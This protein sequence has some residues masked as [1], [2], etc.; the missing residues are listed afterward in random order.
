MGDYVLTSVNR[1]ITLFSHVTPCSFT[2]NRSFFVFVCF[3]CNSPQWARASSFTRVLDHT[4]RHTTVG[5]TPL[6]ESSARRRDL[7]LTTLTADKYPYPCGIRTH[8]LSRRVAA[9]R[10]LRP[11]VQITELPKKND[12]LIIKGK[13]T[14]RRLM[15]YI[16]GAPILDVS[17]SHTTTQHSR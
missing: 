17:R 16:Y 13:L 4:Q 9:N 2:D 11:R 15:S 6:D 5:R 12:D 1:K 8:N 7:Y 3:W 14:L 10:R